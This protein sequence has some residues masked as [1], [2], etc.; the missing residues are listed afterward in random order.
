MRTTASFGGEESSTSRRPWR[1]PEALPTVTA[2]PVTFTLNGCTVVGIETQR[3][4]RSTERAN[5][6]LFTRAAQPARRAQYVSPS[7]FSCVSSGLSGTCSPLSPL[8]ATVGKSSN[9]TLS[10]KHTPAV[11]A[12][13]PTWMNAIRRRNLTALSPLW[14]DE[15]THRLLGSDWWLL[16]ELRVSHHLIVAGNKRPY[17]ARRANS[18]ARPDSWPPFGNGLAATAR[19][20]AAAGSHSSL[21]ARAAPVGAHRLQ[22]SW[23]LPVPALV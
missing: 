11:T 4:S 2:T 10:A 18:R 3:E 19:D 13:P 5:E 1:P 8:F 17:S 9:P 16:A 12:F 23:A 7:R 22:R 6:I 20:G 21:G 15:G 14:P